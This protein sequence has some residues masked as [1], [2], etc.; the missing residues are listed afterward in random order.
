MMV[1]GAKP[2]P[3]GAK[4]FV[5]P[6]EIVHAARKGPIWALDITGKRSNESISAPP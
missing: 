3:D 1:Q 2:I 4:R 5:S 6:N